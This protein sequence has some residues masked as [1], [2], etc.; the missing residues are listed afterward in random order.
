[1]ESTNF[2]AIPLEELNKALSF[3]LHNNYSSFYNQ[4][5][6]EPRLPVASYE[7]FTRIPFLEKA[8]ILAVPLTARIFI[9]EEDV[10]Y[11]SMSS[12][13]TQAK[14]PTII[15][16][17]TF[18]LDVFSKYWFIE[19]ELRE[20]GARKLMLLLPPLAP[21]FI[22]SFLVEKK[23]PSVIGGDIN[24][25]NPMAM[26][27][28][29]VG[30]QGLITT[31]T[32]LEAFI[33]ELRACEFDCAGITWISLGSEYCSEAKLAHFKSVFPNA[34][35]NFRFGT[36]EIGF[37]RGYRCRHLAN[38]KSPST[39]HPFEGALLE[40][41]A[42][43]GTLTP[44]G[45]PGEIVHTDLTK[46]AFPMIR[47]KTGDI[48][49]LERI[50]CPCGNPFTL[51]L[52]GRAGFDVLHAFGVI[53]HTEAIANAVATVKDSIEQTFQMHV[54][55]EQTPRGVLPRLE[56]HLRPQV[57]QLNLKNDPTFTALINKK[58]SASLHLSA[59]ATLQDL[60]ERGVFLPLTI[61]FVDTWKSD[62]KTKHIISH[63]Q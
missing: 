39:F 42:P 16:H 48:G 27:A 61:V 17:A 10:A 49:S 53:L 43:D 3:A 19:D 56:L 37:G 60:V 59:K 11:Y 55:E 4:L 1:M 52:G 31:A 18:Y 34:F 41:C 38:E 13:T 26:M 36:S 8:D 9:P 14:K 45:V 54:F 6:G 2:D 40:I 58:I 44:W 33:H 62:T 63:L 46:K 22:R 57:G 32:I 35:F 47:Y 5:H 30:T 24:K 15:P 12:G 50:A 21:V 28:K 20:F 51:V 25:L 7:E 29:E 23:Y